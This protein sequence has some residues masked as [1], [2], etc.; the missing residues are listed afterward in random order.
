MQ[1]PCHP[2]GFIVSKGL[3]RLCDGGRTASVKNSDVRGADQIGR[4]PKNYVAFNL[5]MMVPARL[6][7]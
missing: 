5:L 4:L 3:E 6:L 7:L 2:S 1:P